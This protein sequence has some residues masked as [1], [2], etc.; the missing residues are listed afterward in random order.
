[1][2]FV[3]RQRWFRLPTLVSL[4]S[5]LILLAAT[6]ARAEP[7][8]HL[9]QI[10]EADRLAWLTD[11]YSA[12][13]IYARAEKAALAAGDKRNA[14]YAK[15]GRLRG[16]M[17]TSG[18]ADL[19]Q[20]LAA[21]LDSA[22]LKGD[23]RL[24]LRLLTVKGDIDL[25]W[26][27]DDAY[28]DWSEVQ[29]LAQKLGD[30]GW[31]NRARGEL[32][33]ISFLKGNTGEAG[34]SVEMALNTAAKTGDVGGQL[35]YMGAI[36]NGL[37][38]AG[39]PQPALTY[40]DKALAFARANP[41]TGF[42]FVVYSTKV[43]THLR[44]G[45]LDE[46]ERF[47]RTAIDEARSGDRRIKQIEL[48][49]MLAKI[50]QRRGD[51]S[52][53]LSYQEQAVELAKAGRVRRLLSDAEHDL[54]DAYRRRGELVRAAKHARAAV[55]ET[56]ASGNRFNLPGRL[57]VLASIQAARG[58]LVEADKTYEQATDVIEGIMVKVPTSIAQARLIGV[59][60]DIYLEN[61]LLAAK[62]QQPAKAFSI[63][64]RA[65]GRALA[66]VLKTVSS[67]PE[68][69]PE[70]RA[71]QRT[72][73]QLQVELMRARSA[74]TRRALLERL[75]E[76]EQ[77]TF[78]SD[79]QP[80][81]RLITTRAR[82]DLRVVQR[83]LRQE[84]ALLE[85]VLADPASYCLVITNRSIAL[86]K[87]PA[88]KDLLGPLDAYIEALKRSDT[89]PQQLASPVYDSLIRPLVLDARLRRLLVVPD[90]RLNLLPYDQLLLDGSRIS[91]VVS[92][93]PSGAVFALLRASAGTE[94]AHAHPLLAIGDV[95][96]DRIATT[97]VPTR[98]ADE[99]IGLYDVSA[100]P[101]LAVL[102]A[103]R[104]ELEAAAGALGRDSVVLMGDRATESVLKAQDLSKFRAL[105]FALH[106]VA[107]RKFPE[108]AA[109]V[110]LSDPAAGEDGLL[111]P[112]EISRFRLSGTVVVLSACETAV[113]PTIG[114]EG[115]LNLAR[116]FLLA[117]AQAVVTTLWTVSDDTTTALMR[118]Y[119][120]ALAA[121]QD[122][123]ESLAAA[124]RLVIE[125]FGPSARPTVAAFQVV[126]VGDAR[127]QPSGRTANNN[128]PVGAEAPCVR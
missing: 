30:S 78:V 5:V 57:R 120:T 71:Q 92:V 116:A 61:F 127:F 72:I 100:P 79:R 126:G 26:D 8:S 38:S 11:W 58:E 51:E 108:R 115:V 65:R 29:R 90:G 19:A 97:K 18:L 125:R 111:Q 40:C 52:R 10:Q 48:L 13:P 55:L 22:L 101:S 91:A 82:T 98:A 74:T 49:L 62:L 4:V 9:S 105:H 96:Y 81:E 107:D 27:I 20:I 41:E 118:Q 93:V 17:Q 109:L 7:P 12:A 6:D 42:P 128:C 104:S 83:A 102:P 3:T 45:Q 113:G 54:A 119:Y 77:G 33:M 88:Q 32:G 87:L 47:A 69:S 64:E 28:N 75:W 31:E 63:I 2:P 16:E 59:M 43:L 121:G 37:L 117:G 21:D 35:R 94:R 14:L 112:R 95:P 67:K 56:Q 76:V 114:Q 85:Y 39:F 70:A 15:F 106:G 99:G 80:Q 1:M 50:A 84:E 23:D 89:K 24:R 103:A 44:L 60:S 46:A 25:E 34:R 86:K 124:K 53:S 122:V 36:A 73:S 66:D 68:T 123:A 110:L